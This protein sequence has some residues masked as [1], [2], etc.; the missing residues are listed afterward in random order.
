MEDDIQTSAEWCII[1]KK[2]QPED[3]HAFQ[4]STECCTVEKEK[5]TED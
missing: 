1:K 5:Q 2:N 4:T 3:I